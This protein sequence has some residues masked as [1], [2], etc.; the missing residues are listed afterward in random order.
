MHI[1]K[2]PVWPKPEFLSRQ[3]VLGLTEQLVYEQAAVCVDGWVWVVLRDAADQERPVPVV[4]R[5][6]EAIANAAYQ[7][8]VLLR[9]L[10]E[11]LRFFHCGYEMRSTGNLSWVLREVLFVRKEGSY[12]LGTW[13]APSD[14]AVFRLSE[15]LGLTAGPQRTLP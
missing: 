13:T 2:Q 3:T 15:T 5:Y 10:P 12:R 1:A 14:E 9:G 8:L 4:Q 11:K 7:E 6:F